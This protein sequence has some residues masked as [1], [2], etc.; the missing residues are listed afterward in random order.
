[1]AVLFSAREIAEAAVEK[2]K[3]EGD[4]TQPCPS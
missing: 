3:R 4:F 1:M 2:E